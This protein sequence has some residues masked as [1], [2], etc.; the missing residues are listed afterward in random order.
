MTYDNTT[1]VLALTVRNIPRSLLS[2]MNMRAQKQG[3]TREQM[4][5]DLLQKEFSAE[6]KI[7][8]AMWDKSSE[9]IQGEATIGGIRFHR[10]MDRT[11]AEK[12]CRELAK[13]V[14]THLVFYE[15]AWYCPIDSLIQVFGELKLPNC[16]VTTYEKGPDGQ[17]IEEP[18]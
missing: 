2:G 8:L 7:I 9:E 1:K 15:G 13:E 12:L 11:E 6:E 17:V 18:K 14:K 16:I 5:R 4:L 10:F 3:T